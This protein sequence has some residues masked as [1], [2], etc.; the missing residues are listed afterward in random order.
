M[1]MQT[2][3]LV[4]QRV[5]KR[6][7]LRRARTPPESTVDKAVSTPAFG[8]TYSGDTACKGLVRA[9]EKDR[10]SGIYRGQY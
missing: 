6:M 5:F 4:A 10:N 2:T 3:R 7:G 9:G 1:A 8:A